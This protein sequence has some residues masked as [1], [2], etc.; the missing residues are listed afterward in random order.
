MGQEVIVGIQ[1]PMPKPFVQ[2]ACACEKVLR[3]HDNVPSLIR[4]IDTYTLDQPKV[5]PPGFKP[6]LALV[7]FVALKSGDVVGEYEIGLRLTKPDGAM[8]PVGK[9]SARFGGGESGVNIQ[10]GFELESPTSGLYWFDVL[11]GDEV[12]TRIPLRLKLRTPADSSPESIERAP[13]QPQTIS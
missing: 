8:N 5:P 4:V 9:R 1:M 7:L 3:E 10:V 6:T 2:V 13:N 12:L 11:W